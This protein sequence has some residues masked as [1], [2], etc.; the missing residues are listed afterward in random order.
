[1][2]TEIGRLGVWTPL[3]A[4]T[5]DES[6]EFAQQLERWGY[7]ALWIPEAV[8][9]DPFCTLA[10]LAARSERLVLATGIANIYAR[11][12]MTLKAIHKTM[13]LLAPAS[14]VEEVVVTASAA[15]DPARAAAFSRKHGIPRTH[16]SYAALVEDPEIDAIYNPLPNGLHAEWTIRALEAG[17]HVLCEKP[18]AANAGE[19]RA[20]ADAA[21][22]ADRI[23]MEAFHWRY[24][25]LAARAKAHVDGGAIG[26]LQH[27]EAAFCIPLLEPGNIRYR[28]DLAGG[29]TMDTGAYTVNMIR[30][31]NGAE[32][33]VVSA[34]ARLSSPGVDRCMRAELAFD[35]G[36]TA[37]MTCSLFSRSLFRLSLRAVGDAGTLSIF[38][39]VA[40]HFFH[41][42]RTRTRTGRTRER[43]RGEPTYTGQLRA[44]VE[45][46]R[47]GKPPPTDGRD[48]VAN[49]A[50]IDAIY[51]HAGLAPRGT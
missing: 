16:A 36:R 49:M 32:P 8:G 25:P 33:R 11:D 30:Y 41:T 3:D 21:D 28:L 13:A 6:A 40:P 44:F 12:P 38:N 9:I 37:R 14:R 45:S 39:P 50:V 42:L 23:L 29:A 24:H 1:M 20:M 4:N 26:A 2:T 47:T 34:N 51:E 10:Y 46:V 17:K 22:A 31:L 19:A 5:P 48:G 43:L 15:R 18:L 7:S 35:D 27:V